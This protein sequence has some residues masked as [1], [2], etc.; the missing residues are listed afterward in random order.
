MALR[1]GVVRT[2]VG[3]SGQ[4]ELDVGAGTGEARP[5]TRGIII[6]RRRSIHLS[7]QDFARGDADRRVAAQNP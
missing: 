2:T 6:P 4:G 1:R 3:G 5:A 7:G